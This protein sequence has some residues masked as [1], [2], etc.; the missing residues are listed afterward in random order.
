MKQLLT[1]LLVLICF[2]SG[3][4][5]WIDKVYTYDSTL[6]V[7]YGTALNFNNEADTLKMDI[8]LPHCDDLLHESKR[9]LLLWIHGGAFLAGSKEDASI[10]NLC[11]QFAKRGYVTA[12][13]NYRLG[14][15]SDDAAWNCN[16]PNYSCVFAADSA[17]W[18]RAM[19]R[20]IQDGKGA[21]RYLINRYDDFRI[22]TA[23]VFVAGESAGAFIA[24]GIALLDTAVER[25]PQTYQIADATL[26]H[27]N[28]YTCTYNTGQTFSGNGIPRPDLGGIEGSIEPTTINYTLKGVGNMYG[29]MAADLLKYIP[30]NKPKPAIYSFHQPCDLVVPI[31]SNRV[32][33][34]ITWCLTN[35]YNCYGITNT[36]KVYGSRTIS[37]WNTVN[38][39]GYS[40]QNEFTNV[41]FPYNF[42]FGQ[43]SCA[44]QANNPCHAY[45]SPPL[46]ENNLASF[47]ADLITTNPVCEPSLVSSDNS[48]NFDEPLISVYPNPATDILKVNTKTNTIN[49]LIIID[50]YGKI[51]FSKKSVNSPY[52]NVNIAN[53]PAGLYFWV[54]D[55]EAGKRFSGRVVKQ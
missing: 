49:Y 5:Q 36:P 23:N 2:S 13:I 11:K 32:M 24:M 15:I 28:S 33:A 14:F 8:Y 40:I 21:L 44:D 4:Q 46:R 10:T 26:P 38:N 39:Y 51:V 47:F 35:G 25:F 3:A 6:N 17:E 54:A 16:Y 45:D 52:Y 7:T 43:A 53:L 31:D 1:P 30:A 34:G 48:F 37:N 29:A 41:N 20:G 22:D 27:P 55:T 18:I 19:Y 12:G 42:L 50:C 9:P